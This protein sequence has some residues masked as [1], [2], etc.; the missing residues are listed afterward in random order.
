MLRMTRFAL[1]AGAS[2]RCLVMILTGVVI[3]I[4]TACSRDGATPREQIEALFD[5]VEAAVEQKDLNTVRDA[6]APTYRD[7]QGHDKRAVMRIAAFHMLRNETVYVLKR[8]QAIE[9]PEQ[10]RANAVVLVAT[11]GRPIASAEALLGIS[12][13]VHRFDIDLIATESGWQIV[14]AEWRRAE[15]QDLL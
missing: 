6:I 5:T 13:D 15:V 3:V 11:A 14:A 7:S 8:I 2:R 9:F 4:G 1:R 12:A 10:S